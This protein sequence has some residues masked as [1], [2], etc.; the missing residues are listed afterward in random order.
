MIRVVLFDLDGVIRHFDPHHVRSIEKLHG[1]ESGAIE[2]FAFSTAVIEQVTT[3]RITRQDWI[4]RIAA[5]IENDAAASEWGR[6][7]AR[8]DP[9]VLELAAEIRHAGCMTAILTN[10]TDTIPEEVTE[11]GLSHHFHPI[12]NS[13]TIGYTKPDERAFQHVVDQLDRPANEFFFTDD[14]PAK[15]VGAAA[16]GMATHHFQGVPGLRAA[17][18]SHGVDLR[19]AR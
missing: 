18:R 12:F 19:S 4:A 13:A 5:H 7:P 6:Q 17:L 1:I 14:S 16:L 2:R 3:G 10:G 8:V 15:L 9:A 11:A